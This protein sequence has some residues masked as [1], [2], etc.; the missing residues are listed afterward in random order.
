MD[1]QLVRQ[2]YGGH[3]LC[4][5]PSPPQPLHLAY[6]LSSHYATLR[7][8]CICRATVLRLAAKQELPAGTADSLLRQ[9]V[10][11]EPDVSPTVRALGLRTLCCI[12]L[13]QVRRAGTSQGAEGLREGRWSQAAS[14]ACWHGCKAACLKGCR[15]L[16]LSQACD[17]SILA[18]T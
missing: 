14:P 8:A 5:L 1:Q 18:S 6:R 10:M 3:M 2:A 17:R 16:K 15:R 11:P 9:L 13:G 7:D 12:E 4:Q